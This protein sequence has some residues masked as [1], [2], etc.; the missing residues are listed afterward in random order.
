MSTLRAASRLFTE[1]VILLPGSILV[2]FAIGVVQHYVAFGVR[3]YGFGNDAFR[4]A[5]FEGGILGAMLGIPTGLITYYG[6]LKR[7]VDVDVI[8]CT[9]GGALV[10][11]AILG[12]I[13]FWPSALMTPILTF[14]LAFMMDQ[15]KQ[16]RITS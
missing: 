14:T 12:L 3:G 13:F 8:I 11:G 6:I 1:F 7:R 2:G 4:L 9:V 5:S 16:Q 15:R 10:G